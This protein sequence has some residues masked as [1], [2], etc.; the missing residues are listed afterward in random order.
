MANTNSQEYYKSKLLT[1][2]AFGDICDFT[3]K[4]TA[5]L[6]YMSQMLDRT[7]SM[8]E[9]EGLPETIPQEQMELILQT[10]GWTVIPK[11]ELMPDGNF[12]A[13]GVGASLGG[14]PDVY[15]RATEA[16][17]SNPAL[18]LNTFRF[19]IGVDCVVIK[20]DSMY[21]GLLPLM[22][23]YA[24]MLV[25]NDI[26]MNIADINARI[27]DLITAP[28]DNTKKG[29]EQFLTDIKAGK[30]GVVADNAFLE[31]I[32]AQPY[33]ATG[34]NNIT[35]LIELH[36]YIKASFYNEIGLNANFN[37]KREYIGSEES[38]LNDSALLPYVNNMLECRQRG[39]DELYK[40]TGLRVTVKLASSWQVQKQTVMSDEESEKGVDKDEPIETD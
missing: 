8:F 9:Y 32:K 25:E 33:G 20:N 36:Q 27:I 31:G 34:S 39:F 7:Q 19:K 23:R 40:L 16:L 21:Q 5:V 12:Y 6:N 11:R 22:N 1:C 30:L 4:R 14:V 18:K 26:T 17:V 2:G 37:M 38:G 35:Q 29:A 24:S 13:F 15:Y 3:D 10:K 28:D